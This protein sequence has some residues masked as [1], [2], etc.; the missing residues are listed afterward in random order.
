MRAQPLERV[1]PLELLA[2]VDDAGAR[3]VFDERLRGFGDQ[4]FARRRERGRAMHGH[5]AADAMTE[6]DETIE[7]ERIAQHRE[8][9]PRLV[10]HEAGV[11]RIRARIRLTEAEAIVSDHAPPRA[12]GQRLRKRSPQTNA[13]ER[14]VQQHDGRRIVRRAR[15]MRRGPAS[16][17]QASAPG[18]DPAIFGG[19]RL[20]VHVRH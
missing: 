2:R 5:P 19:V 9:T 14:I 3:A 13:A 20:V 12:C 1:A 8:K 11:E 10:A 4:R 15:A 17:E 16:R 18:I 6:R 7:A